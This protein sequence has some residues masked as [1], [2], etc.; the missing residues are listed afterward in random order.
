MARLYSE[1]GFGN[2]M[3]KKVNVPVEPEILVSALLTWMIMKLRMGGE[4]G[5]EGL[6]PRG[7]CPTHL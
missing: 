1:L 5:A 6:S 4:E 2:V 7:G 3:W